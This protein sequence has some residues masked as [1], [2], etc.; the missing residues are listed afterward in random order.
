LRR[1]WR[2][3]LADAET[4]EQAWA[5]AHGVT[6]NHV[7]EVTL[8]RQGEDILRAVHA[9]VLARE[10]MIAKRIAASLAA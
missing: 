10:K 7:R 1:R 6:G 4:N 9:F 5:Q 2:V 8:G 3:C